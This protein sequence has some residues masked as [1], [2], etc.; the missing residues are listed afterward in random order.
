M[1]L[2]VWTLSILN[3]SF[4][5][6]LFHV[7]RAMTTQLRHSASKNFEYHHNYAGKILR[8]ILRWKIPA[9]QEYG[10]L[11]N[12]L[13]E[14]KQ[15][16]TPVLVWRKILVSQ[17]NCEQEWWQQLALYHFH[18]SCL[19]QR[20]RHLNLGV[21]I[22]VWRAGALTKWRHLFQGVLD[23]PQTALRRILLPKIK[24][25]NHPSWIVSTGSW[26]K[27]PG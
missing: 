1:P 15:G 19:P 2:N 16:P 9:T 3:I 14:G 17:V 12:F 8:G 7:L 23:S 22:H 24:F 26:G 11:K 27:S 20:L 6:L 25:V 18:H 5:Y 21:F 4:A 10:L 13:L